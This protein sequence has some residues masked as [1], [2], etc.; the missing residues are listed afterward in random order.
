MSKVRI[1]PTLRAATG[2]QREVEAEGDTVREVLDDLVS[3][4]PSLRG[5]LLNGDDELAPFV[6]VYVGQ[7]D[8]RTLDGLDTPVTEGATVILLPAMAGG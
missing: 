6:N 8:V 5:Q 7:E 3:Q 1:P 4:F 2:G